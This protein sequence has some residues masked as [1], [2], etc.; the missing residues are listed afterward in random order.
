MAEKLFW[1]GSVGPLIYDDEDTVD[2]GGGNPIPQ[3]AL[4]YEKPTTGALVD[5]DVALDE[6]GTVISSLDSSTN[7]ALVS[8][9]EN[10][11]ITES[12]ISSQYEN[13]STIDSILSLIHI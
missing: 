8:I 3:K 4:Q 9:G 13:L 2:D 12:K 1:I 7:S 6:H 10:F 5:I 11:S